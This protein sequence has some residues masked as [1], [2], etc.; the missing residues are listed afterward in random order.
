M[1]ERAQGI[2][3]R[4]HPLTETSLI[5]RWLTAKQG[6]ISTVAK[7]ARRSKS[8]FRGKLDLFY[9]TEFTF[10]RSRRSELHSLSELTVKDAHNFLREDL[11][12]LHQA[13]YGVTLIEQVTETETPL[14][15]IFELMR[16][17]LAALPRQTQRSSTVFAFELKLLKE[18][19]L[20]PMLDE[21]RL[22]NGAKQLV[23]LFSD[24]DWESIWRL[25][26]S[27]PQVNE[28]RQ[29]LHGFLIFHLGKIPAGR[30]AALG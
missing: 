12:Y 6:R 16:E 25:K 15:S 26:L 18:L 29:F 11:G 17:F 4:V 20:Q 5:I 10:R 30:T 3:L 19:G 28:L 8:P 7:G 24:A 14:N 21:S 23:R 22:T 2:V 1:D 13:A 9:L 27:A